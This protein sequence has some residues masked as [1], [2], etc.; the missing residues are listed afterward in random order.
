MFATY[1]LY[2]CLLLGVQV[3]LTPT[4]GPTR[5]VDLSSATE[6]TVA[7]AADGKQVT[8]PTEQL[9]RLRF[10]T[11]PVNAIDSAQLM[12]T[13]GSRVAISS[14]TLANDEL[15]VHSPSWTDTKA[16][17]R[18][19]VHSILL[20]PKISDAQRTQWEKFSENQPA[21]DVVVLQRKD[22]ELQA[23]EG[24]IQAID[25]ETVHFVFDGDTIEVKRSRIVGLL[26]V[27][28]Q[29]VAT[30]PSRAQLSTVDG[31]VL[32]VAKLESGDDGLKVSTMNGVVLTV[33]YARVRD[34]DFAATSTAYLSDLEPE[35]QN[36]VPYLELPQIADLDTEWFRPQP[37]RQLSRHALE[38]T[39][40]DGSTS[41]VTKGLGLH[42]RTELVYRL[43]GEYRRFA[44]VCSM[45]NRHSG[46]AVEIIVKLD[47][48]E[49][50]RVNLSTDSG[51]V[52]LDVDVAGAN[53][54]TILVEYGDEID[55]G[56]HV[57]LCDAR[58]LK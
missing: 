15:Q 8:L 54:L 51:N 44:S 34:L 21:A 7:Y 41:T 31:A 28:S 23:I 53:R 16:I 18:K 12:L 32:K 14:A 26:F 30:Q 35:S 52:P 1:S 50:S 29:S 9:R 55:I 5:T 45:S 4:D 48:R 27:A 36:F 22:K 56:D 25:E 13:D 39:G 49:V 37:D 2:V 42:S 17:S 57:N 20:Q 24:A 58:L 46:G 40:S 6:S 19:S 3:E 11:A 38:L 43:A 47:G 10:S 33:P